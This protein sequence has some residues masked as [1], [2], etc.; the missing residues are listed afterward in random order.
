M[1]NL[2][3]II[4][5]EGKN[6]SIANAAKLFGF[7]NVRFLF[8][9]SAINNKFKKPSLILIVDANE[10]NFT[11]LIY[12][13]SKLIKELNVN[14]KVYEAKQS[15]LYE[16]TIHQNTIS[17]ESPESKIKDFVALRGINNPESI[18]FKEPKIAKYILERNLKCA[19]RVLGIDSEVSANNPNFMFNSPVVALEE[20]ANIEPAKEK[21]STFPESKISI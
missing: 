13:E 2:K 10:K 14:I 5:N 19:D 18:E 12:L 4:E 9:K 20:R 16:A 3:E 6:H 17:I 15:K 8:E 1:K 7:T 11:H 21:P